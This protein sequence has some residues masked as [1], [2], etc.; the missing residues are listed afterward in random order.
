MVRSYVSMR[1]VNFP[2]K[3]N[4]GF[5]VFKSE[6]PSSVLISKVSPESANW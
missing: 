3:I 5:H 6:L 1:E 2:T 4:R